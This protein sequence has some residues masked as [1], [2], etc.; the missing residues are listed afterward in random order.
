MA[1]Y[2][3]QR[4]ERNGFYGQRSVSPPLREQIGK[5]LWNRKLGKTMAEAMRN[6]PQVLSE[7]DL[8]ITQARGDVD[9]VLN[10]RSLLPEH[11]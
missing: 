7:T 6:L 2:I 9:T 4:P 10:I 8:L 5:S 3:L 11:L 1:N